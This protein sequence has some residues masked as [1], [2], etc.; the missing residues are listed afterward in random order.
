MNK[1]E[2]LM[3][4]PISSAPVDGTIIEVSWKDGNGCLRHGKDFIEDGVWQNH[5]DKCQQF[6]VIGSIEG[7]ATS[8][9]SGDA[10]YTHWRHVIEGVSKDI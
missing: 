8:G 5:E 7:V 10:P 9:P 4:R 3:W 6:D 2:E 1:F